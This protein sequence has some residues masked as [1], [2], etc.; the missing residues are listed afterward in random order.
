MR[1]F[2]KFCP[3]I[4]YISLNECSGFDDECLLALIGAKELVCLEVNYGG[5]SEAGIEMF[6]DKHLMLISALNSQIGRESDILH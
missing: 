2:V 3:K 1:A 5:Y 6:Q 4:A